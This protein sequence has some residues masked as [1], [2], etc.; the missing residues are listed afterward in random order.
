MLGALLT[1]GQVASP[2]AMSVPESPFCPDADGEEK[3]RSCGK[4]SETGP[5]WTYP[6]G[7]A[8]IVDVIEKRGEGGKGK[9]KKG[10]QEYGGQLALPSNPRSSPPLIDDHRGT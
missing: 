9:V 1:A 8:G 6:S 4:K 10:V 5:A 3:E 2:F 7:A